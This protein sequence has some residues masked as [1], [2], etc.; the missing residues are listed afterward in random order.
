MKLKILRQIM[1]MSRYAFMGIFL[2]CFLSSMAIPKDG[3]GQTSIDSIYITVQAKNEKLTKVLSKIENR[4]SFRFSYF[5]G[6]IDTDVSLNISVIDESLGN[7]LRDIS[8]KTNLKF[9]RVNEQIF[10]HKKKASEPPLEENLEDTQQQ[11]I[12]GKVTSPTDNEPLPGVSIL[13]KGT[14]TGTTTDMNGDYSLSASQGDILQFSFIGYETQNIEVTNQSIINVSLVEDLAQLEE[15]VVVGY[16]TVKKSDLTGAVS[17]IKAEEI[18]AIPVT[19]FDQAIQGRASGVQVTQSNN[20]PGGGV[21]IRIRGGNSLTTGVEPLYVVDGFPIASAS[22]TL[23]NPLAAIPPSDIQSIEILKDASATALYGSRGANGVILITT[24]RGAVGA[25]TVTFSTSVGVQSV[26]NTYDIMD[27]QTFARMTNEA[28][29]NSGFPE[30]FPANVIP[31]LE[32]FDYQDLILRDAL[33]TNYS[34]GVS[35]GNEIS[36]YAVTAN[37]FDQEGIIE[38]SS[39]ERFSLRANNDIKISDRF[40]LGSSLGI[41]RSNLLGIQTDQVLGVTNSAISYLPYVPVRDADG[42]F[43]PS[44]LDGDTYLT[45]LNSFANPVQTVEEVERETVSNRILS[46][47]FVEVEL[48]KNLTAKISVG[49]DIVS[50]KFAFWSPSTTAGGNANASQNRVS[51]ENWLNENILTY[52]NTFDKH[53]LNVVAGF[54]QQ[55]DVRETLNTSG[56][57]FDLDALGPFGLSTTTTD[58]VF[59]SKQRWDLLSYLARINYTFNDRLLLTAAFRTDGSS[60]FAEGNK[61]GY[62]PS[63]AIAYRLGEEDFIQETGFI[64]DLKVRTSY[65]ITGNQNIPLYSTLDL[66]SSG[67]VGAPT[68]GGGADVIPRLPFFAADLGNLPN[69]DLQWERTATFDVGLEVGLY[70]NR[71]TAE[72]GYYNKNTTDLI[73]TQTLPQESGVGAK[74]INAGSISNKGFEVTLTTRNFVGDDF[75][76][77]T[78]A[79]FT[80]NKNE[81]TDLNGQ[82]DLPLTS[83]LGGDFNQF[84][85]IR[86]GE[87]IGNLFGFIFD[88]VY[89]TGDSDIPAGNEPGDIRFRDIAG[90]GDDGNEPD[91]IINGADRTIIGNAQPD[92]FWGMTNNLSYKGFDLSIF[93]QGVHGNE[94]WNWNRMAGESLR[95]DVGALASVS[96]WWT[97]E[98][99]SNTVPRP[100]RSRVD[101][102]STRHVEDASFIRIRNITLGY[103]L[104]TDKINFISSGR[105]YVSAQNLHTFTK[106]KGFDPDVNSFGQSTTNLGVDRGSYPLART[107]NVGFDITF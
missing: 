64:S 86:E 3:K 25:P 82:D 97:P 79:N 49:A 99:P 38:N 101:V 13:I 91:G 52:N 40:N 73:L 102:L 106:Y 70:D 7:V 8:K 104:P 39:F 4:T 42:N 9:K 16:G 1:I 74:L 18:N 57:N 41:S 94:V 11:V 65:G 12:K 78:S 80:A 85:I 46:N 43:I 95:S 59:N 21:S 2:Q 58:E 30:A 81:V 75:Q 15:V 68:T 5:K 67:L 93:I 69:P 17:S 44:S 19:S 50:S 87:P 27:S 105:I 28:Y 98:N 60:R 83:S 84:S 32:T 33:L 96:D 72:F 34:V 71:I 36:K 14:S 103:S 61:W 6:L 45:V 53:A 47:L 23:S 66:L 48:V 10:I 24:K 62:F 54:T 29:V 35:G 88:G 55:R 76:W 22:G 92:F 77:T 37:Y 56:Q 100:L 20:A 31:T 107:F 26:I 90:G 51:Q 63:W 89:Q